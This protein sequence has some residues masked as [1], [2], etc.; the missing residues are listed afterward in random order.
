[1]NDWYL[2]DPKRLNNQ[3]KRSIADYVESNGIL[4]PKRFDSLEQAKNSGLPIIARSEHVQDYDNVSGLLKSMLYLN[5]KYLNELQCEE[6]LKENLFKLKRI[7]DRVKI[8]CH[9]LKLDKE[10]FKQEVSFSFWE[11]LKGIN[12]KIIADS[13]IKNKYHILSDSDHYLAYTLFEN[14]EVI[15]QWG[16][17]LKQKE[18]LTALINLY[19]NVRNLE[20]FDPNHC[21]IMEVQSFEGKNYFLQYHRCRD[22]ESTSF[23]LDRRPT[24]DE[25]E[26]LFVRGATLPEGMKC[27]T[28]VRYKFE[29]SPDIIKDLTTIE[30]DGSFDINY[31]T[32]ITNI[33]TR[34]RKL[35]MIGS[36]N[37]Y[38]IMNTFCTDH[39]PVSKLFKPNIS[40]I[41]DKNT[42]LISDKEDTYLLH[43][44]RDEKKDQQIDLYVISDGRKAYVKRI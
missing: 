14:G 8:Y 22:F 34:K 6:E 44:A 40:I 36:P 39:D 25:I 5:N 11:F 18:D 15:N 1:M 23:V 26:T 38:R 7:E 41:Y 37:K 33:M 32:I 19:E 9:L 29:L 2:E 43:K 21:P 42:N 30:E 16:S 27:K 3:P 28:T 12:R 20:K 13:S 35:Q 10:R 31:L 17:L 4:V 24:K